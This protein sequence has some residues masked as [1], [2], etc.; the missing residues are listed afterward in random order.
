MDRSD[1]ILLVCYGLL[2]MIDIYTTKKIS[3]HSNTVKELRQLNLN[4]WE[5]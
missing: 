1:I 2:F 5:L 3:D 4:T